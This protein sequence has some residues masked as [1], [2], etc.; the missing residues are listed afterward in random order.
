V[1][2]GGGGGGGKGETGRG[3]GGGGGGVGEKPG[4]ARAINMG[5]SVGRTNGRYDASE[6]RD[7]FLTDLSNPRGFLSA[8]SHIPSRKMLDMEI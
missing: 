3:G 1:W 6:L 7:A 4:A 8:F 2:G 5:R